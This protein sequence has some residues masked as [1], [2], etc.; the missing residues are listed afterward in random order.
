MRATRGPLSARRTLVAWP[1]RLTRAFATFCSAFFATDLKTVQGT[2]HVPYV[3]VNAFGARNGGPSP[4]ARAYPRG[5]AAHSLVEVRHACCDGCSVGYWM[6][7]AP[8]SGIFYNVGRTIAFAN[9]HIAC[10]HYF[11]KDHKVCVAWHSGLSRPF[12]PTAAEWQ[13]ILGLRHAVASDGYD[14]VQFLDAP[15]RNSEVVDLRDGEGSP[16]CVDEMARRPRPRPSTRINTP[17]KRLVQDYFFAAP[18]DSKWTVSDVARANQ[19]C[20]PA[21]R[22]FDLFR[23]GWLG[24]RPCECDWRRPILNC[25]GTASARVAEPGE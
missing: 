25:L 1:H 11:G 10:E 23:S 14:S 21:G 18:A 9:R 4:Y 22:P 8:G 2:T 16:T 17:Q 3:Y 15:G 19:T 12:P 5:V 7:V 24:A 13:L 20:H 6:S